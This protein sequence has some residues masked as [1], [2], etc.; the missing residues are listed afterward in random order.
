MDA[1]ERALA[2]DPSLSD[3]H[4]AKGRVLTGLGRYDE[5]IGELNMALSLDRGVL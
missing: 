4:A 5:A 2:L 1:A 3:A